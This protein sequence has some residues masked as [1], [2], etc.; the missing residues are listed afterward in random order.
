MNLLGLPGDIQALIVTMLGDA[1]DEEE[2]R[3]AL[4]NLFRATSASLQAAPTL[5]ALLKRRYACLLCPRGHSR[6]RAA[7]FDA[8][9]FKTDAITP[10][11]GADISSLPQLFA[12]SEM[13]WRAAQLIKL[14]EDTVHADCPY[15][16]NLHGENP[17]GNL[18]RQV[19]LLRVTLEE[20]TTPSGLL[21]FKSASELRRAIVSLLMRINKLVHKK[22]ILV[23]QVEHAYPHDELLRNVCRTLHAFCMRF[24]DALGVDN[25]NN[26]DAE[27][28][29]GDRLELRELLLRVVLDKLDSPAGLLEHERPVALMQK[30]VKDI[31]VIASNDPEM[32]DDIKDNDRAEYNRLLETFIRALGSFPE[33]QPVN[34]RK[35]W[36]R[37]GH[38][39]GR[40]AITTIFGIKQTEL[41][42]SNW[43][44]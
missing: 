34:G 39:H 18:A 37:R 22:T 38:R 21:T 26:A 1:W 15:W 2:S 3:L 19:Y 20:L 13:T 31:V 7:A 30:L 32:V 25:I 24:M 12:T 29:T 23:G 11:S 43:W 9:T 6:A 44:C 36:I 41:S 10:K 40:W 5:L 42:D 14:I 17:S 27:W 16:C 28:G 8:K 33:A 4:Q 35:L